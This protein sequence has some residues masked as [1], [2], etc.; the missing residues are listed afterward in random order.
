MT[1]FPSL[2]S[3]LPGSSSLNLRVRVNPVLGIP[4]T[5]HVSLKTGFKVRRS[6]CVR[7]IM[8]WRS[9]E[10]PEGSYFVERIARM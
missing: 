7:N 6:V 4:E 5:N 2:S 8:D 1:L 3:R 9:S 10:R